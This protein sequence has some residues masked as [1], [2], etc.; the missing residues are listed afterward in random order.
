MSF[1]LMALN[2]SIINPCPGPTDKRL[3]VRKV[4]W[5]MGQ[6]DI[7]GGVSGGV[8]RVVTL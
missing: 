3:S 8:P 5:L 1:I 7:F 2:A 4:A 6:G